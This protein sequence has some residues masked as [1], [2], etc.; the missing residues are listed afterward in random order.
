MTI[1]SSKGYF[2]H[3][4][5]RLRLRFLRRTLPSCNHLTCLVLHRGQGFSRS[6]TSRI[7]N[8][9]EVREAS[10]PRPFL[11]EMESLNATNCNRT[12]SVDGWRLQWQANQWIVNL[13]VTQGEDLAASNLRANGAAE[14][15]ARDAA[16]FGMVLRAQFVLIDKGAVKQK[17]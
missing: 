16:Y 17:R 12:D 6:A 2:E 14:S 11:R 9:G 15:P 8:R 1:R 10:K 5:P 7:R 13:Q 4:S 3:S